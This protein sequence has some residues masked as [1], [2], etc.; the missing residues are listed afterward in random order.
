MSSESTKSKDF[1]IRHDDGIYAGKHLVIDLVGAKRLDDLPLVEATLREC[2]AV[3]NATLLHIHLHHFTPNGGI[4][5]V[6]VLAESHIAMHSWPERGYAA[7]DIFMC[8]AADPD[9]C[10]EVINRAFTPRKTLVKE[11]LRGQGELRET[12][13]PRRT[14]FPPPPIPRA[15]RAFNPLSPLEGAETPMSNEEENNRKR[16]IYE[17]VWIGELWNLGNPEGGR[18]LADDF[19][20]HR[21]FPAFANNK[22]G[23]IEMALDWTRAFPDMRFAVEDMIVEGDQLVARYTARG[24][25]QGTFVG[26]AATGVAVELTGIDIFRFRNEEVTDWWHNEDM[27]GLMETIQRARPK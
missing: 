6:A 2:T 24:T 1:F 7:L 11:L 21:P 14:T 20:D 27:Q 18:C 23:H 4:S 12:L 10:I 15:P 9:A 8:G 3:A 13:A 25:H 16:H 17:H 19:R 22:A 5:A 26:I